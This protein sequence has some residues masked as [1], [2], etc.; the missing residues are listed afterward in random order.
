MYMLSP[1]F[2]RQV[3]ADANRLAMPK[4]N[5]TQLAAIRVPVPPLAEQSEIGALL[6]ELLTDL[7]ALEARL[8]AALDTLEPLGAERCR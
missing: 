3:T 5:Q 8:Q 2:L 7:A 6:G 1:G 4:V